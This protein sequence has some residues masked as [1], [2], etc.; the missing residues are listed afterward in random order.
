MKRGDIVT[1]TWDLPHAPP[2][3]RVVDLQ[4][5]LDPGHTS[6][7]RPVTAV[8]VRVDW[9]PNAEGERDK[10]LDERWWPV[11]ELVVVSAVDALAELI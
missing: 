6:R 4:F 5:G 8:R 10:A 7:R 1:V 3:G 2:R 11:N 9:G